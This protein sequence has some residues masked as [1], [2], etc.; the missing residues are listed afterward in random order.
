MKVLL[1]VDIISG[2]VLVDNLVEY[3]TRQAMGEGRPVPVW[4]VNP[5]ITWRPERAA[6]IGTKNYH[7]YKRVCSYNNN[8]QKKNAPNWNE[9]SLYRLAILA[10]GERPFDQ[11][12]AK[13]GLPVKSCQAMYNVMKKAGVV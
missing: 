2:Q 1:R 7:L 8:R 12:A 13:L 10:K 9:H 3:Y 6:G 5:A 11:I 4:Q